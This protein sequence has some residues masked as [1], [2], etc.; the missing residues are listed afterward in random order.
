MMG[1]TC[2]SGGAGCDFYEGITCN[3]E[4]MTCAAVQFV[5]PGQACGYINMQNVF[6]VAGAE[7]VSGTCLAAA[8]V[9]QPC[10]LVSGPICIV[11]SHCIVSAGADGGT[12]GTCQIYDATMCH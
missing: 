10:D 8:P 9:G 11:P 6:C 7:C 1:A 12:A 3:A 4:T 2:L 5:G